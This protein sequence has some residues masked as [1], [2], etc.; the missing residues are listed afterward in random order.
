MNRIITLASIALSFG[1]ALPGSAVAQTA[2]DLVG[3]WTNVGNINIRADGSRVSVSAQMGR[4]WRSLT[5][6]VALRSSTSIPTRLN[7]R[8][9]TVRKAR[10][11]KTR[12][13][14]REALPFTA[15]TRS[16]RTR[17]SAS[18]S[19][20]ARIRTGPEPSKSEWSFRSQVTN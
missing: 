15:P 17:P 11:P 10:P 6:A 5:P 19:R 7:S 3:T 1:I 2:A 9:T 13:R 20:A 18:R 4:V 14:W 12:Q 8:P 16:A